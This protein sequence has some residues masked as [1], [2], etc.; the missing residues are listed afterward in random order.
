MSSRPAALR[1]LETDTIDGHGQL[2]YEESSDPKRE[3]LRGRS[4]RTKMLPW[5]NRVEAE[6]DA[7]PKAPSRVKAS[8]LRALRALRAPSE[9]RPKPEPQPKI[10]R[11]PATAHAEIERIKQK[12]AEAAEEAE[13]KVALKAAELKAA[14]LHATEL[15]RADLEGA[16]VFPGGERDSDERP[17]MAFP[18][19]KLEGDESSCAAVRRELK[20]E[21]GVTVGADPQQLEPVQAAKW[22]VRHWLCFDW[23]GVA[24]EREPK[25]GHRLRWVQLQSIED[26]NLSKSAWLVLPQLMAAIGGES[27]YASGGTELDY[28]HLHLHLHL[29]EGG[30]QPDGG[31][32]EALDSAA[33]SEHPSQQDSPIS[34]Q[35]MHEKRVAKEAAAVRVATEAAAELETA[36]RART[37]VASAPVLEMERTPVPSLVPS[38]EPEAAST[39][40]VPAPS[41]ESEKSLEEMKASLNAILGETSAL[42]SKWT[43][44]VQ[45]E[46]ADHE[47]LP[48]KEQGGKQSDELEEQRSA[49]ASV[50]PLEQEVERLQ[51]QLAVEELELKELKA[52]LAKSLARLDDGKDGE[53]KQ[54][55]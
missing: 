12:R 25:K 26:E 5:R 31:E 54:R 13:R 53:D 20:E 44:E 38:L 10:G 8:G 2:A 27:G 3:E 49:E 39:A 15:K 33:E 36:E 52:R 35:R 48:L 19:G 16:L 45:R 55:A 11:R 47:P 46:P 4:M 41:V 17:A 24:V 23:T 14:E 51:G 22:L 28:L 40:M 37:A 43:G 9:R 34:M 6:R 42:L 29:P 7:S 21:T 32:D 30:T 50:Q 18:G 1:A